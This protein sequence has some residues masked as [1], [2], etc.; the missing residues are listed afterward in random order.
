VSRVLSS[1]GGLVCLGL[2]G[3][4]GYVAFDTA[5]PL[6]APAPLPALVVEQPV[7]DFG[8]V[9]QM[10]AH[11]AEF[12]L[13]N[14]FP[15]AV[16]VI[17]V[18]GSCSCAEATV[19]PRRLEPGQA[20]TL[21]VAW[22]TGGKRGRASD[23]VHVFAVQVG[24]PPAPCQ[25][26]QVRVTAEVQPDVAADPVEIRFDRDKPGK[27]EVRFRPGRMSDA[28]ILS[29]Y[30]SWSGLETVTDQATGTVTIRFD[31]AKHTSEV[32]RADVLVQTNSPKEP[33]IRIP[34]EFSQ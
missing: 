16:D 31:P 12:R 22:R 33:W 26:V 34:V 13:V 9:G 5:E 19:N 2:A 25:V 23:S 20:A 7:H 4:A 14:H 21:T 30:A 11:H 29:A 17:G 6:P 28:K 27:A 1:I 32:A 24:D 3:A 8:V 18:A 10:E 15:T